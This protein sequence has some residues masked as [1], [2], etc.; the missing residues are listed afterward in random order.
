VSEIAKVLA[1]REQDVIS[2]N[3]RLAAPDYS[4]NAPVQTDGDGERQD[5][6]VDETDNQETAAA[7]REELTACKALL[8][9]ALKTLNDRQR[10]ILTERRLKDNPTTLDKLSLQHGVSRER[11]RQIEEGALKKLQKSSKSIP[12]D[13]G[14]TSHR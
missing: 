6:L 13:P 9:D 3:R 12:G 8:A 5:W 10:H 1:V 7:E 11:I 2:M 14:S 4:L